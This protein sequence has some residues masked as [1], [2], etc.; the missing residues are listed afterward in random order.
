MFKWVQNKYF[1]SNLEKCHSLTTSESEVAIKISRNLIKSQKR[2]K[3]LDVNIEGRLNFDHHIQK[4]CKKVSKKL[5]ALSKVS[6]R[7]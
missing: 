1:K 2:T 5:H 7:K 4:L 6:G 3:L